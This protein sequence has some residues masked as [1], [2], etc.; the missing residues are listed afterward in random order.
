MSTNNTT[1]TMDAS[2]ED[3]R[4]VQGIE[5]KDRGGSGLTTGPADW[6]QQ[7]SV[8]IYCL[9]VDNINTVL[10]LPSCCL[11]LIFFSSDSFFQFAV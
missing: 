10:F 8:D 4:R 5:D 11:V 2:A 1:T 9:Q 3:R 6:Q 7:R